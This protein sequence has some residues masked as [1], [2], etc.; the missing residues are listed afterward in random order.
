MFYRI[1]REHGRHLNTCRICRPHQA[2]VASLRKSV[3]S[4]LKRGGAAKTSRTLAYLGA[5]SWRDVADALQEKVEAYNR[6]HRQKIRGLDYHLDHIKPVNAF[7]GKNMQAC[8]HITN[9]Q[10]VPAG[11]NLRKRDKWTPAADAF[12]RKNIIYNHGFRGIFLP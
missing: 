7:G 4:A 3:R 2:L 11:V 9:M 1:C 12:W 10:P 5:K 6:R 8:C